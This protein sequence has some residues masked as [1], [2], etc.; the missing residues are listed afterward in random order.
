V[1]AVVSGAEVTVRTDAPV[2]FA[3][4]E[5]RHVSFGHDACAI[6]ERLG[7]RHRRKKGHHRHRVRC[8]VAA[9]TAEASPAA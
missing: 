1:P 9:V 6:E 3:V 2:E 7:G 4:D 8:E 5:G